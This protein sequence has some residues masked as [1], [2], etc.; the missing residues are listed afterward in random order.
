MAFHAEQLAPVFAILTP[1]VFPAAFVRT[2]VNTSVTMSPEVKK[3][4]LGILWEAPQER[5]PVTKLEAARGAQEWRRFLSTCKSFQVC[6]KRLHTE[7]VPAW[8][9]AET[10]SCVLCQ[11]CRSRQP[12]TTNVLGAGSDGRVVPCKLLAVLVVRE[13]SN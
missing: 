8:E 3:F 5:T 7:G 13:A 10:L 6:C 1:D 2:L 11:T 12:L 9:G 4:G